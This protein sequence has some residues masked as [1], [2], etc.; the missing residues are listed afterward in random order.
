MSGFLTY[1]AFVLLFL[2]GPADTVQPSAIY[3]D[4]AD[5]NRNHILRIKFFCEVDCF[6]IHAVMKYRKIQIFFCFQKIHIASDCIKNSKTLL[7]KIRKFNHIK[8]VQLQNIFNSLFQSVLEF[9]SVSD[10]PC[11]IDEPDHSKANISSRYPSLYAGS[12]P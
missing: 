6:V 8:A 1:F 12:T 11:F 2:F 4:M 7:G 10:N 5:F 3:C 9:G